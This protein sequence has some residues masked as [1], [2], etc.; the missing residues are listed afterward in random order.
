MMLKDKTAIITGAASPRGI[1]KATARRFAAQGCRVAIFDLDEEAAMNAARDIGPEHIGVVCD[2]RDPAFCRKAVGDVMARFGHVDILINNAG[3]SQPDRLM[4]ITQENFDLVIDSS[5]RG[6][7]NMAQAS[8]PSMI[9][10]RTGAIVSIG[11]IA[12]QIG[13]GIF[14]GPHYSAAKGGIHSLT[15]SMAR[16][17][18]QHNI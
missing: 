14:G 16:E 3:I 7:L 8:V 6:S 4:D 15:K 10:R 1:G 5:L 11:S 13:G 2:V 17:L 9:D 12:A 18:A